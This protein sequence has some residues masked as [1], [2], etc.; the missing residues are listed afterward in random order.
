M[1]G[2]SVPQY[3]IFKIGTDKLKYSNWNLTITKKE[4]FRYQE[5]VS[6]FEGQ[7][8]R[9]MANK[10]LKKNI[11]YIDFSKIFFIL[12]K[13]LDATPSDFAT[14]S[15]TPSAMFP[16]FSINFES[17]LITIFPRTSLHSNT[18]L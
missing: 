10:I 11:K 2:I 12:P 14:T 6:L 17:K 7:E 15:A 1:A 3:E 13:A 8:F 9:I 5:L 18:Y 4:A 16:T